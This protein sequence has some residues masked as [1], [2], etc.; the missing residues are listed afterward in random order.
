MAK[1]NKNTYYGSSVPLV[2]KNAAFTGAGLSFAAGESYKLLRT[3]LG[4]CLPDNG[5]KCHVIGITSATQGE[6]KSTTSVNLGYSLAE[7]GYH[8]L[9]MD[10]DMRL[11]TISARLSLNAAPGLSNLIA[12]NSNG[13]TVQQSGIQNNLYVVASGDIP[14]NPSELLTSDRMGVILDEFSKYYD[15]IVLDLPP[16]NIVSD[17]LAVSRLTDGIVLVV[18]ENYSDKRSIRD[19]VAKFRFS[20]AN[21]LGFVLTCAGIDTKSGYKKTGT[22]YGKYR[23]GLSYARYRKSARRHGYG[24]YGYGYDRGTDSYRQNADILRSVSNADKNE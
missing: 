1:K 2:E 7:A 9:L 5:K 18:R 22:N 20:N 13:S 14:P 3:N 12:G 23:Y 4:F 21:I 24:G 8:T 11:P 6:G 10:C 16:V 15:Y 19:A 17:A